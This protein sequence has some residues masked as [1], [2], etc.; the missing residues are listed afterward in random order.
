MVRDL[1]VGELRA[2]KLTRYLGGSKLNQLGMLY[3]QAGVHLRLAQL[4]QLP[5]DLFARR[6]EARRADVE[7][8]WHFEDYTGS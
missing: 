5:D 7:R 4:D 3:A 2:L 6:V 1:L 8:P